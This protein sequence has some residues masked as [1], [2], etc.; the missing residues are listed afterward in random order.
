M[1]TGSHDGILFPRNVSKD[2]NY[3]LFRRT[4]CRTIPLEYSHSKSFRYVNT[5]VYELPANAFDGDL[6][7]P[8]NACACKDNKCLRKGLGN[9][10]PCYY[11]IPAAIS[12]P[13]FLHGDK[14]LFNKIDGLKPDNKKHG[15]Q[16]IIQPVCII[17]NIVFSLLS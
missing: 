4:F 11:S 2:T 12:F 1:L 15:S 17:L 7:D 14:T 9:M 3:R 16:M 5:N 8:R 10:A 13:H 6:D